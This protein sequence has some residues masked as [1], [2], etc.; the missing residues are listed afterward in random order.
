MVTKQQQE[1]FESSTQI[2]KGYAVIHKHRIVD[3]SNSIAGA[4]HKAIKY[5]NTLPNDD[6]LHI[7]DLTNQMHVRTLKTEPLHSFEEG[8]GDMIKSF[9]QKP[10]GT[11]PVNNV[12]HTV[13]AQLSTKKGIEPFQ[14]GV[15]DEGTHKVFK[16]RM[17]CPQGSKDALFAKLN[18]SFF[19]LDNGSEVENPNGGETPLEERGVYPSELSSLVACDLLNEEE[20]DSLHDQGYPCGAAKKVLKLMQEV[21]EKLDILNNMDNYTYKE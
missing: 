15:D 10:T 20:L 4:H 17:L 21:K 14:K 19:D 2:K 8:G 9:N 7:Y 18:D 12:S 16:I 5:G 1:G 6:S 3:T 11:N 13:P